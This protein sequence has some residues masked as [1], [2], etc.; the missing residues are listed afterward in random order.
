MVRVCKG[1]GQPEGEVRL[2][3]RLLCP[4]CGLKRMKAS[5]EQLWAKEGPLYEKWRTGM[6]AGLRR[7]WEKEV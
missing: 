3:Q 2:S 6:E 7:F 4:E 1:C 5:W